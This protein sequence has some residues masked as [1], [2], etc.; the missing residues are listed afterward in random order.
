[1]IPAEL[2]KVTI[3]AEARAEVDRLRERAQYEQ[4]AGYRQMRGAL[5]MM[6][7]AAIREPHEQRAAPVSEPVPVPPPAP[8]GVISSRLVETIPSPPPPVFDA[9]QYG[10]YLR[11]VGAATGTRTDLERESAWRLAIE[12]GPFIGPSPTCPECDGTGMVWAE[13]CTCGTGPSGYYGMHE[14]YCGAEPCPAGCP[15][16]PEAAAS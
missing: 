2:A 13:R 12:A 5:D 16:K 15:F 1:M 11:A 7:F 9:R 10:P 4:T 3:T 14:R 6:P 8:L